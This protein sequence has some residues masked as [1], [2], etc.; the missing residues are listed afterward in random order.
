MRQ[1][2]SSVVW[3]QAWLRKRQCVGGSAFVYTLLWALLQNWSFLCLIRILHR[4]LVRKRISHSLSNAA[5]AGS[6]CLEG[7]TAMFLLTFFLR[8][9]QPPGIVLPMLHCMLELT[10]VPPP[11]ASLQIFSVGSATAGRMF[12]YQRKTAFPRTFARPLSCCTLHFG[13]IPPFFSALPF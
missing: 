7:N 11:T 1:A 3:L 13:C 10:A 6:F 5:G 12:I 4:I 8:R 2:V 9:L